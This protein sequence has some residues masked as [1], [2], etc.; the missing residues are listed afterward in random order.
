M[1]LEIINTEWTNDKRGNV[2]EIRCTV[3][4]ARFFEFVTK[5]RPLCPICSETDYIENMRDRWV[6]KQ[7]TKKGKKDKKDK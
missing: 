5:W 6:K 3:C 7:K 2:Y 4:T 1:S